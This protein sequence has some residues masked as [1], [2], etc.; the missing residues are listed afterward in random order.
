MKTVFAT[1][2]AAVSVL[3][4]TGCGGG[5][6]DA[7]PANVAGTWSGPFTLTYKGQTASGTTI[8][9]LTQDG[10]NVSGTMGGT[11]IPTSGVVD[12]NNVALVSTS[13]FTWTWELTAN[14]DSMSGT[15]VVT[16]GGLDGQAEGTVSLTRTSAAGVHIAQGTDNGSDMESVM[17]GLL[18]KTQQK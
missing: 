17:T 11:K 4:L 14:G 9:V 5:G 8:F 15:Y 1:M 13:Q 6:D 7:S 16:G 18:K 10:K 12:G 3:F 2:V